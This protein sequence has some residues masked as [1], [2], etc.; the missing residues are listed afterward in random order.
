MISVKVRVR[1]DNDD[2]CSPCFLVYRFLELV[3]YRTF[4]SDVVV[5]FCRLV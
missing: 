1:Y 2:L 4:L 3:V 5:L